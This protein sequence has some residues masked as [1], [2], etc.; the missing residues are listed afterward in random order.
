M[1]NDSRNEDNSPVPTR[2][3]TEEPPEENKA[4]DPPLTP[5]SQRRAGSNIM[6]KIESLNAAAQRSRT[7]TKSFR[8]E[9]DNRAKKDEVSEAGI[10]DEIIDNKMNEN[11]SRKEEEEGE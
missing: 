11:A 4:D 8:G 5:K 1:G 9:R 3:Q 10:N 7:P 6:S 2:K